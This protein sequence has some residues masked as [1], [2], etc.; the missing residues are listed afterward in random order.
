VFS[1]LYTGNASAFVPVATR[2]ALGAAAPLSTP[3]LQARVALCLDLPQN[4][5]VNVAPLALALATRSATHAQW[6]GAPSTRALPAR[7]MAALLYEHAAREA[8]YRYQLGDPQPRNLLL[9]SHLS[10]GFQR[11]LDDREPLV[12]QPAAVA[13]G[14]LAA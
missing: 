11:L 7:R 5:A 2:I 3:T 13:R 12:W 6:I 8:V 4:S 10:D 14:F 9:A 1:Q